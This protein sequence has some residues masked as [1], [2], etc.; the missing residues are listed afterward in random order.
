MKSSK[1]SLSEIKDRYGDE[2][3]TSITASSDDIS[4]EDMIADEE[5]VITISNQGYIKRTALTEYRT[6]S[7]GGV[8]SKG[9]KTKE[10]DFTE[11]LFVATT[12]NYL[13]IFTDKGKVYWMRVYEVPEGGKATKGRPIQN[14]I[15]IEMGEKV[16]AIINVLN[17]KDEDYIN[18]NFLFF[19]TKKGQIK[20]TTLESYSR[21]RTNGINAITINEGDELLDVRL[22]NGDCHVVMAKRSGKAIRFHESAV[23]S[24]GRTAAGVRGVTLEKENDEVVGLV[25]VSDLETNLLV[26]SEKGYGKRSDL[27]DYRV[28]NRGGKGVK[29]INVTE[30]TG[31]L[32]AIKQVVDG[33]GLMIINKSGIT[34]RMSVNQLRVMG[35]ATQGVRLI[36]LSD[37]DAIS[38]V[39]KIA[40]MGS[41]E[42]EETRNR[43]RRYTTRDS[44]AEEAKRSRISSYK[45]LYL[46]G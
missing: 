18:N 3:R 11:H 44:S 39:A 13:L 24:M 21:P 1:P 41:D 32:V 46:K 27:E 43:R 6:Q 36:K 17:L 5:M 45:Q 25:C 15:N 9:V 34:I 8:G 37:K 35:R 29:T 22:T 28:T 2:R 20:K 4:I 30:K 10:E 26:V 14:L 38:S 16:Q 42:E 31:D 12:H 40:N 33:D 19:A 23:R 7:R